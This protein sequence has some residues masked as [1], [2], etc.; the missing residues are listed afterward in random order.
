ML[1][2]H[3]DN[4]YKLALDQASPMIDLTIGQQLPDTDGLFYRIL[5]NSLQGQVF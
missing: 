5:N 3:D 2:A 1:H 4:G